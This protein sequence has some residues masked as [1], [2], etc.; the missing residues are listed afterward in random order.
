MF[1]DH[2]TLTRQST[3]DRSFAHKQSSDLPWARE[4]AMIEVRTGV[5]NQ[6]R[7][8]ITFLQRET[9]YKSPKLDVL[10]C[11]QGEQDP[12]W[13]TEGR[14]QSGTQP[15]DL[16]PLTNILAQC[17]EMAKCT[18]VLSRACEFQREEENGNAQ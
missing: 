17:K 3:L 14:P 9:Q 4:R 5:T 10:T 12:K 13:R 1:H 16:R 11:A 18:T 8:P 2:L 6:W 15:L 7:N